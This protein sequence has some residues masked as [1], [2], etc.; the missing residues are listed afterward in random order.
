MICCA[1]KKPIFFYY[2]HIHVHR[3][4]AAARLTR[5]LEDCVFRP[6]RHRAAEGGG[7]GR[8][9]GGSGGGDGDRAAVGDQVEVGLD[10]E[11]KEEHD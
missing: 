4:A 6:L 11:Q 9:G 5:Q 7:G 3:A 10:I 1:E 8:V 2:L